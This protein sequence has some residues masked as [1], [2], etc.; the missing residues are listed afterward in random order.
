[1]YMYMYNEIWFMHAYNTRH[2][3]VSKAFYSQSQ[4][5]NLK[6]WCGPLCLTSLSLSVPTSPAL[7]PTIIRSPLE[8]H[9]SPFSLSIYARKLERLGLQESLLNVKIKE[10]R[11]IYKRRHASFETRSSKKNV[12]PRNDIT[13][14]MTGVL[15]NVH[16]PWASNLADTGA[17]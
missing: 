6:S 7:A 4:V 3:S 12:W 8:M 10:I 2:S 16:A 9:W 14:P 15:N 13:G 11:L 5:L 17:I 1:M